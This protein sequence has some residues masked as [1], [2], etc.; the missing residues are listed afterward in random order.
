MQFRLVQTLAGE[1]PRFALVTDQPHILAEHAPSVR[2]RLGKL[3][4]ARDVV[5]HTG[6]A[7]V[8][9][10]PGAVVAA[11][12]RRIA[13]DRVVWATSA[14]AVAW[15]AASSLDCDARGFLRSTATSNAFRILSFSPPGTA[16]RRTA[17]AA[18]VRRFSRSAKDHR[19]RRTCVARPA[20]S[21][22]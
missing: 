13:A 15:L 16:R 17:T 1:A 6:S 2:E 20:T 21:R 12:G 7:A 19:S 9:V 22:S 5:L 11:N 4:I 14:A 10:E 8:A 3:L 18:E